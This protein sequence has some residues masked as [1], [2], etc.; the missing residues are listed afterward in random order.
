MWAEKP[1]WGQY[2]DM[3]SHFGYR[4]GRFSRRRV[5]DVWTQEEAKNILPWLGVYR[6]YVPG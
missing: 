2:A 1:E 4:P 5:S 3:W 6:K